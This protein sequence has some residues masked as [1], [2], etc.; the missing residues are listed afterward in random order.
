VRQ[1][2]FDGPVWV[3][4]NGIIVVKELGELGQ[5]TGERSLV[6]IKL[7]SLE[8]KTPSKTE[9]CVRDFSSSFHVWGGGSTPFMKLQLLLVLFRR[10]EFAC[11]R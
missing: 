5:P 9:L 7:V 1:L 10:F 11:Y 8:M 3:D 2:L 4:L 6:H